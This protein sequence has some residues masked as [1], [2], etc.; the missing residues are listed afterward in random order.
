MFERKDTFMQEYDKGSYECNTCGSGSP[1]D[2]T[3]CTIDYTGPTGPAGPMGPTG[4][5]GRRECPGVRAR[6]EI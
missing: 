1:T 5:G 3:G 4:Q 6:K 2:L